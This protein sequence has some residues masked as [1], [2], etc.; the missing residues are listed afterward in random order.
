MDCRFY[1]F[2]VVIDNI[3]LVFLGKI[4]VS[5]IFFFVVFKYYVLME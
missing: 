1:C 5:C 3:D 4:G 2:E